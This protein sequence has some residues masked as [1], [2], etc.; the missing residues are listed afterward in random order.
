LIAEVCGQ[1]Q[2]AMGPATGRSAAA[3]VLLVGTAWK[4]ATA[5]L[6]RSTW[7]SSHELGLTGIS[8]PRAGSLSHFDDDTADEEARA[9]LADAVECQYGCLL[10]DFL[11][12]LVERQDAVGAEFDELRQQTL[13]D[14]IR[15]GAQPLTGI[16]RRVAAKFAIVGAT[17][18]LALRHD[19]LALAPGCGS[20][21]AAMLFGRWLQNWRARDGNVHRVAAQ[22]LQQTLR[23]CLPHLP[24][25]DQ[26]CKLLPLGF[27]GKHEQHE[28]LWIFPNKFQVLCGDLDAT[29]CV[30][31]LDHYGALMK[32]RKGLQFRKR[33]PGALI[34]SLSP[35]E[36]EP[37]ESFYAI[38]VN[39]IDAALG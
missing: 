28:I 33:L 3:A 19:V 32:A 7:R 38:R 25:F 23:E 17:L 30:E 8:S 34:D 18:E 16:E 11:R 27:R 20:G 24:T 14:L 9:M 35:G 12:K 36:C 13:G 21:C 29:V 1:Q 22:W 4:T 26:Q 2:F 39:F 10:P 37:V 5:R 31:A 15:T 6:S